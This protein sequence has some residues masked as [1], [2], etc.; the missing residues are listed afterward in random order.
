MP[1]RLAVFGIGGDEC[2]A[3]VAIEN[4]AARGGDQSAA[5]YASADVRHLPS[6][7]ARLNVDGFEKLAARIS[8]SAPRSSAVKRLARLPPLV[9]LAVD[10]TGLLR[11]HIE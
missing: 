10:V 3:G 8:R 4:E 1:Q 7:F 2:P 9:V 6:D 5:E 11:E